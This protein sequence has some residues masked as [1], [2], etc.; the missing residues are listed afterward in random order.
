MFEFIVWY[1]LVW[2]IDND[3]YLSQ[4]SNQL[5]TVYTSYW[6]SKDDIKDFYIKWRKSPVFALKGTAICILMHPLIFLR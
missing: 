4:F 1:F 3:I 6:G 5:S 2:N